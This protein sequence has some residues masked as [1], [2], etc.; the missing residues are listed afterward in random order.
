MGM[1]SLRTVR[2]LSCRELRVCRF[3]AGGD[4][5]GKQGPCVLVV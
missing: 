5:G 2:G 4:T 1:Q 3:V